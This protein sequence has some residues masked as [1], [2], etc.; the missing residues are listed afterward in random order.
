MISYVRYLG[1]ALW[2]SKLVA[3]YPHPTGLYPAGK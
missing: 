1:K 2:P 3:L